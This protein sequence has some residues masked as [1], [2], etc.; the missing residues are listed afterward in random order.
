MAKRAP[1]LPGWRIKTATLAKPQALESVLNDA[2][3]EPVIYPMFMTDGWFV[4]SA[5][6]KRLQQVPHAT[7]L[8]PLGVDPDLPEVVALA[9]E[10]ELDRQGWHAAETTLLVAAHGSGRSANSARDTV[11]FVKRLTEVIR[12]ETIHIGYVE[13][14]PH[15]DDVTILCPPKSICLPFFAADGGHVQED[16]RD[17][18][19]TS[20]FSGPRMDPVGLLPGI[21]ELIARG[22]S[23]AA[24]ASN[25]R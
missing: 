11:Q 24:S 8:P 13:Q 12:F 16:I 4:Q 22:I 15:L 25:A 21:K 2:G 1:D 20:G 7:I 9:L 23:R 3:A 19:Q 10:A 18:L 17:A 14:P 5:L 6:R